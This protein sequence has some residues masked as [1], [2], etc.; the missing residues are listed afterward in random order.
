VC[1]KR[2]SLAVLMHVADSTRPLT[3]APCALLC[4]PFLP[5]M[6]CWLGRLS[7]MTRCR[8]VRVCLLQGWCIACCVL[9]CCRLRLVL[10]AVAPPLSAPLGV[11][12]PKPPRGK[13]WSPSC[14]VCFQSRSIS[15]QN[16][17]KGKT[18]QSEASRRFS[19]QLEA[20]FKGS[21]R[22]SSRLK[23]FPTEKTSPCRISRRKKIQL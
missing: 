20:N 4:V 23:G 15:R 1:S 10:L 18:R 9:L 16:L 19:R 17:K 22:D 2:P 14:F 12:R 5:L 21:Y 11:L 13:A 3:G 8:R 7:Q 6:F